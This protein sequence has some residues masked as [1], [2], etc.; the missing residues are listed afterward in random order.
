MKNIIF[1]LL[2]LTMVL[3]G[4]TQSS[5]AA[6][7]VGRADDQGGS[8]FQGAIDDKP[9]PLTLNQRE[10]RKKGLEAKLAGKAYGK[11]H[12]V[13][14]GQYVELVREGDGAIWTVLGEFADL[15]HN[16]LPEPDRTVDNKSIWVPDFSRDYY[17]DLLFNGA[18][19]PNSVRSFYIEQSSNRYAVHGDVTDWIP[20]PNNAAYY[21]DNPDSNVWF[22]LEDTVDGWYNAQ[23]AAG[24][25]DAEINAYLSQFDVYDRYDYNSN[26]N[27][28]E[29]DGYIDTFQSVHS[30]QG[31]E[32]GAPAWAIWSHS[33]YVRYELWGLAGPAFNPLGGIQVG[34]SDYWVGKY[35][36]QPENGGVG[37]FA[38][39]YGHDMG[40]PDL[41]D[42]YGENGTGFW[43][44]MSSGSWI[45]E[46]KDTIGN[47]PSHM[48]AWEKFQ[49]GW[50]NYEVA[51]AGVRSV[52][53]LA[54][55]EFNTKQAQGLFVILPQ[56]EGADG[57]HNH[58][59]VAEYRTYK[60]YD[61]GLKVG[62]YY[63][64]YLENPLLGNFVDRF[65]YQDGL[66]IN[67]WDTSQA[68]NNTAL[69]PGHGLLLPVDAHPQT[70][71][72]VDG[73]RW[74]NRIQT[75]DSTFTLAPTDGIPNIH[76]NSVLSPVSSLPAVKVFDDR[77][78]YYDP[79]NPLGSVITPNTGTQILI[80]SISAQDSLMQIEVRPTK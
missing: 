71:Y 55:M 8:G 11:V 38:H 17:M 27:F 70:L 1:T 59:Y 12:E 4:A 75:Y 76:Q 53:K 63:F 66:L 5:F 36:I 9:D 18:P 51:R 46:G 60:G 15:P 3:A 33:W 73:G 78:S 19:G 52:H 25:T 13:A 67:Y 54:P 21:D 80:R 34:N 30:G 28:D 29:P 23:K 41:Y 20:V 74:R 79:T 37:A 64:G 62:P 47:K 45:D 32:E 2:V 56:K 72:R 49:L 68:D 42:Y 57:N 7:P 48:G 77:N 58:Y 44:L 26:G 43:T 31:E 24:K 39:E 65:A 6:P 40:L 35:T 10:R 22:F 69:H 14:R 16:S 61:D 50:L